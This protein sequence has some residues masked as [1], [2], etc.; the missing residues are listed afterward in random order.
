MRKLS[1]REVQWLPKLTEWE[2]SRVDIGDLA[3]VPL[4][5]CSSNPS[6]MEKQSQLFSGGLQTHQ[7]QLCFGCVGICK[8]CGS[9]PDPVVSLD[10]LHLLWEQHPGPLLLSCDVPVGA[11]LSLG[12]MHHSVLKD[13][14]VCLFWF[15]DY[16]EK[17]LGKNQLWFSV[18]N[19]TEG[20]GAGVCHRG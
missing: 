11:A 6:W 17:P 18:Q 14:N 20:T 10:L 9:R 5:P 1:P 15:L 2:D 8:W 16:L 19:R 3:W 7:W 12:K 13:L 4:I